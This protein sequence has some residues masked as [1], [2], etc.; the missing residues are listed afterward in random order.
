MHQTRVATAEDREL[1]DDLVKS[2]EV[3]W[4]SRETSTGA[5]ERR[6]LLEPRADDGVAW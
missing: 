6:R 3:D 4:H 1:F 5:R 2:I